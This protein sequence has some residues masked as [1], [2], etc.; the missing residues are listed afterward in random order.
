S[1]VGLSVIL[2]TFPDGRKKAMLEILDAKKPRYAQA[3]TEQLC[4]LD[5]DKL[6]PKII[7]L[8]EKI[9]VGRIL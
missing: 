3:V 6:P 8:F 2:L 4:K 9:K 5:S 1:I 7:E